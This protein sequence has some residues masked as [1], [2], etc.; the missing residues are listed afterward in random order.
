MCTLRFETTCWCNVESGRWVT[1]NCC[2]LC[3]FCVDIHLGWVLRKICQYIKYIMIQPNNMTAFICYDSFNLLWSNQT[4][5]C[6][7]NTRA[8][9]CTNLNTPT[10]HFSS[11]FSSKTNFLEQSTCWAAVFAAPDRSMLE[12]LFLANSLSVR[13]FEVL[14]F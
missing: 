14:C 10:T 11:I 5:A 9:T 8:H 1:S 2:G 4:H 12:A 7:M 6:Y 13:L 3:M